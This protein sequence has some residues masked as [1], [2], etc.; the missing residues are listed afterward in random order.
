M[1]LPR[2][3]ASSDGRAPV[4]TAV[5][6]VPGARSSGTVP[7]LGRG[8]YWETSEECPM[9]VD[10]VYWSGLGLIFVQKVGYE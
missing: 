3:N 7:P 5:H 8:L 2:R 1:V 4:G 9:E 6:D 10:G